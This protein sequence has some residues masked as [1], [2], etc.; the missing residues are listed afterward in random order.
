MQYNAT[1]FHPDLT[2]QI[3]QGAAFAERMN[4]ILLEAPTK[5]DAAK[6]AFKEIGA[7]LVRQGYGSYWNRARVLL[8]AALRYRTDAY[9]PGLG[10]ALERIG[11]LLRE[12]GYTEGWT[13]FDLEIRP[14]LCWPDSF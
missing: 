7:A 5:Q 3:A 8:W 6:L 4:A 11:H 9:E 14:W 10:D 13:I 1:S 12:H 2:Q